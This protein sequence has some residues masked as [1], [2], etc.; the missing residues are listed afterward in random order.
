GTLSR[1]RSLA[2]RPLIE[3][4]LV[5]AVI[6]LMLPWFGAMR[7]QSGRDGRFADDALAV[8]GVPS[9]VL[10]GLCVAYGA[11]AG[12]CVRESVCGWSP[13]T[14]RTGPVERI[15]ATL[16]NAVSQVTQAFLSPLRDA[17]IRLAEAQ[18]FIDRYAIGPGDSDG[19]RP[20]A[21]AFAH[22]QS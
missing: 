13:A 6:A 20:L 21:C 12:E 11:L 9:S 4:A 19:P 3:V 1:E 15:P 22:V 7:Q 5:V 2:W 10:P 17:Q 8:R 14:R 16:G 18:P